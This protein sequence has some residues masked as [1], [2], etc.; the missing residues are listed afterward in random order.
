MRRTSEMLKLSV[1]GESSLPKRLFCNDVFGLTLLFVRFIIGFGV[2]YVRFT[3][4][5]NFEGVE[6]INSGEPANVLI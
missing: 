2:Q 1:S 4:G 3:G 6:C 5:E